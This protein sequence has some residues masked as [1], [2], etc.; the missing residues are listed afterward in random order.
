MEKG[1]LSGRALLD[2]SSVSQSTCRSAVEEEF[3]VFL[4]I[5]FF[6][7]GTIP[8]RATISWSAGQERLYWCH[9]LDVLLRVP[10]SIWI[11]RLLWWVCANNS[12]Q[13]VWEWLTFNCNS[14]TWGRLESSASSTWHRWIPVW[15]GQRSA[16]QEVSRVFWSLEMRRSTCASERLSNAAD[17][18][19]LMPDFE[20]R[21]QQR[22]LRSRLCRLQAEA[23]L[24][25]A[26]WHAVHQE[27]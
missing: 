19:R 17:L 10:H 8:L 6:F 23:D 24:H 3:L 16:R 13:E 22:N 20:L 14:T 21:A 11:Y 2:E 9:L 26:C 27:L 15:T 12:S 25:S 18:R 4:I 5:F 7:R 1:N